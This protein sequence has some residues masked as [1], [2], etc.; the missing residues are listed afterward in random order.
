MQHVVYF[1]AVAEGKI[2]ESQAVLAEVGTLKARKKEIEVKPKF[3]VL[4]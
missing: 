2:D 3:M 1:V 4:L